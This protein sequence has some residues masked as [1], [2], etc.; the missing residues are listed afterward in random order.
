MIARSVIDDFSVYSDKAIVYTINDLEDDVTVDNA[1]LVVKESIGDA[2]DDAL[3]TKAITTSDQAGIGQIVNGDNSAVLTFRLTDP[4]TGTLTPL[5]WYSVAIKAWLS[6]GEQQ[7]IELGT[8]IP[9]P[10]GVFATSP[11]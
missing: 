4:E 11:T 2:D 3:I 9:Q 5:A 6:S 7:A 8:M 10:A 1:W